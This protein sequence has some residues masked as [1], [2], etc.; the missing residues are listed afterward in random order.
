MA[1][2]EVKGKTRE[3]PPRFPKREGPLDPEVIAK[4]IVEKALADDEPKKK[5]K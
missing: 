1:R 2:E 5:R 3:V 4:E